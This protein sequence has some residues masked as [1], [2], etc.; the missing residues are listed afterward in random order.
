MGP[1]WQE[2]GDIRRMRPGQTVWHVIF[3][4]EEGENRGREDVVSSP[5]GIEMNQYEHATGELSDRVRR[6]EERMEG[7]SWRG[8][9]GTS[10]AGES[11]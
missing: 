7:L 2:T 6:L 9:G 10:A 11:G 5:P 8:R 4:S 1:P 3:T